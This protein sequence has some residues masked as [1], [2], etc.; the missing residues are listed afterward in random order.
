MQELRQRAIGEM[1]ATVDDYAPPDTFAALDMLTKALAT[2]DDAAGPD[3]KQVKAEAIGGLLFHQKALGWLEYRCPGK[4]VA[5]LEGLRGHSG[6]ASQVS[7]VCTAITREAKAIEKAAKARSHLRAVDPLPDGYESPIDAFDGAPTE[8]RDYSVPRG[9]RVDSSGVWLVRQRD[10]EDISELVCSAPM[11]VTGFGSD[12]ETEECVIEVAWRIG[13]SWRRKVVPLSTAKD[14]RAIIGA[15]GGLGAPVSSANARTVVHYIDHMLSTSLDRETTTETRSI[16]RMGWV[17]VEGAWSFVWGRSVIGPSQLTVQADEGFAQ[18]ADAC[19]SAG[20]W[21]GYLH[22]MR[23]L[24]SAVG[25]WLM[26]WACIASVLLEPL[27]LPGYTIDLA[28]DTS[29]GKSTSMI[30]GLSAVGRPA[31]VGGKLG[32][33]GSWKDTPANIERTAAFL[34]HIPIALDDSKE[35]RSDEDV[36]R[37]LYQHARGVEKGRGRPDGNRWRSQWRS[38]LCSNGEASILSVSRDGGARARTLVIGGSMLGEESAHGA[39]LAEASEAAAKAN[40]GHLLPRVVRHIMG[41]GGFGALR[42]AFEPLREYAAAQTDESVARRLSKAVAALTL[43]RQL[44]AEVGLEPPR[45]CD[46]LRVAMEACRRSGEDADQPRAAM[47]RLFAW[48]AANRARFWWPGAR[49]APPGGWVGRWDHTSE[50]GGSQTPTDG[51]DRIAIAPAEVEGI[52]DRQ[53][54]DTA[55]AIAAWH[56]RGWLDSPPGKHRTRKTRMAGSR[57]RLLVIHRAAVE[58]ADA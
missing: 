29:K 53:G 57:P 47:D 14:S 19:V 32:L 21:E 38:W 31:E 55:N 13:R 49:Q 40:H 28:G 16:S 43:A 4:A 30:V 44:C 6:L 27:G 45:G 36:A 33:M 39:S 46:P 10:G 1:R 3:A 25:P 56:A 37:T 12:V 51:W 7:K 48:C 41:N 50:V 42:K 5:L 35:R 18:L 52:L 23:R 22:M 24:D 58:S 34:Q 9:Y 54:F 17:Q 20:T 26:T 8:G 15:L 2:V 11:V